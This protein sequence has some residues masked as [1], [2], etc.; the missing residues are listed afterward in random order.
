MTG[1]LFRFFLAGVILLLI[2]ACG[3]GYATK[4]PPVADLQSQTRTDKLNAALTMGVAATSQDTS[5]GEYRIGPDDVL[6]IKADNLDELSESVRVNDRGEIVLPLVGTLRVKGMTTSDVERDITKKIARYVE[7]PVVNVTVKEYRSQRITVVGAV[8]SPQVYAINGQYH[9]LDMLMMA[10]GLSDDAGRICYIIRPLKDKD[11]ERGSGKGVRRRA[12]TI[13]IDL[14]KLLIKGDYSLNV[15]VYANDI[16]NVPRGGVVF[17]DGKVNAPGS[18]ALSPN[19][20]LVE[21]ITMAKGLSAEASSSDVKIFRDNGNGGRDVITA[22]Y[23]DIRKGKKPDILLEEN[24]IIIVPKNGLKS[25][26]GSFLKTVRGL[27]TLG[28]YSVF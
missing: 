24:D 22:D 2:S 11:D 7:H 3:G 25:F 13:I 4:T 20:T 12:E 10:G 6:A 8:R 1:R 15:P 28:T 21:A 5:G 14:N 23:S 27:V 18:Y 17:V 26:V 19:M 16:I 9:L